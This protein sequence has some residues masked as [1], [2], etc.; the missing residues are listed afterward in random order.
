MQYYYAIENYFLYLTEHT[1][2]EVIKLDPGGSPRR[3]WGKSPTDS[4]LKILGEAEIQLQTELLENT[5]FK[6]GKQKL[7]FFCPILEVIL[8][9]KM[10]LYKLIICNRLFFVAIIF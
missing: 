6:S 8:K 9:I 1:V 10:F 3:V 7:D 4:V 2:G 5:T